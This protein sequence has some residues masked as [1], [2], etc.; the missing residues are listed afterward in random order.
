VIS[1]HA[2]MRVVCR[3]GGCWRRIGRHASGRSGTAAAG[4]QL[5]AWPSLLWK[6]EPFHSADRN[7]RR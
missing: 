3:S 5:C 1:S 7:G 2:A 4:F 6:V